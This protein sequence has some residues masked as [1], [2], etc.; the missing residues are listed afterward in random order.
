ME[1]YQLY[2]RVYKCSY[3]YNLIRDVSRIEHTLKRFIDYPIRA[4]FRVSIHNRGDRVSLDEEQGLLLARFQFHSER[5]RHSILILAY[6]REKRCDKSYQAVRRN[7]N[8]EE[9]AQSWLLMKRVARKGDEYA[10]GH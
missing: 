6:I 10:D 8:P 4:I 5:G 9:T 7:D 2:T 3:I 1:I